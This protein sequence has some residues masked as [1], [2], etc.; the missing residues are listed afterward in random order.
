MLKFL[1]A[2]GTYKHDHSQA[3]LIIMRLLSYQAMTNAG[4][5]LLTKHLTFVRYYLCEF[6][7]L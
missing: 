2:V 3:H 7:F 4:H 1:F 6:Q 5:I